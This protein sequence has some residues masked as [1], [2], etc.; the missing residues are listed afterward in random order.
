[1]LKEVERLSALYDV[2]IVDHIAAMDMG[3]QRQQE[4][5]V[6]GRVVRQLKTV[7]DRCG[8]PVVV[9]HQVGR[10]ERQRQDTYRPPK[11]EDLYGSAL[12]EHTASIVLGIYR[13]LD[14]EGRNLLSEYNKGANVQMW[15]HELGMGVQCLKARHGARR[16]D[17]HL[18]TARNED[19]HR[20]DRL[21]DDDPD[22]DG[23]NRNDML[24]AKQ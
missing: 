13:S 8:I 3:N 16:Y 5:Q 18:M 14:Q 12:I 21:V 17:L 11:L 15:R 20:T 4:R 23:V 1:M 6:Y 24:R 19:G 10:G 2:V 9:A 22:Y 7:A